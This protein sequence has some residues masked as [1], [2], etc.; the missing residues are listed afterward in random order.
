M[1][2]VYLMPNGKVAS[3]DLGDGRVSLVSRAKFKECCCPPPAPCECP[4]E[5]WPPSEWPCGGLLEEY[6]V[7]YDSGWIPAINPDG[8]S[9]GDFEV[10]IKGKG[11]IRFDNRV[12]EK[13]RWAAARA[14]ETWT[15]DGSKRRQD[16]VET[17]LGTPGGIIGSSLQIK[18]TGVEPDC[19][20]STLGYAQFDVGLSLYR[21]PGG[22]KFTG[23]TPTG[24]YE[25]FP[26]S[27]GGNNFP[28]TVS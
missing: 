21:A 2:G 8:T 19:R 14:F 28:F 25:A 4:C 15:N 20:W 6:Y 9:K 22:V 16:G 23:L 24:R 11:N 1:P 7:V 17:N 27:M 12:F 3:V 5:T 10:R 26:D 18:L 13:C